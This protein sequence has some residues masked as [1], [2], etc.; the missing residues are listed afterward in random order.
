MWALAE[1]PAVALMAVQKPRQDLKTA[2][3]RRLSAG[4]TASCVFPFD[5]IAFR[6]LV[7]ADAALRSGLGSLTRP[8]ISRPEFD[9]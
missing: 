9:A 8:E 1:T 5:V 6:N 7:Y 4:L 2:S 3:W